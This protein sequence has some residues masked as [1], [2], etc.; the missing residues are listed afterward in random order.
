MA[1]SQKTGDYERSNSPPANDLFIEWTYTYDLDNLAFIVDSKAHFSL[2]AIAQKPSYQMDPVPLFGCARRR[3][4]S[5]ETPP[6]L[7]AKLAGSQGAVSWRGSGTLLWMFRFYLHHIPFNLVPA[8]DSASPTSHARPGERVDRR[9]IWH[10]IHITPVLD[11]FSRHARF[12]EV[13]P[14]GNCSK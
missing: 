2:P 10:I 8:F 13:L 12:R 11:V 4:L 6:S 1:S 7:I 3:C 14:R 9:D 5:L